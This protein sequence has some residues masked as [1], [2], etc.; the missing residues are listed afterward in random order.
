MIRPVLTELALFIAPFAAYAIFLLA[1]R[2][3]VLERS[4]WPPKTL[5]GLAIVACMLMI[6]SFIYLSHFAGSPPGTTYVPAHYD[7]DGSF[8]PGQFK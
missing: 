4:S 6:G 5:A 8:V 3:A 2:S 1:T 7:S